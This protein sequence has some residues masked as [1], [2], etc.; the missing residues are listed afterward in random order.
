MVT[1]DA[2]IEVE[3]KTIELKKE[4]PLSKDENK[5]KFNEAVGKEAKKE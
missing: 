1:K 2:E 3:D 4:T 5:K